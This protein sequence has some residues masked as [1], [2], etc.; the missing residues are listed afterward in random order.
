MKKVLLYLSALSTITTH[1]AFKPNGNI[2]H[3]DR[4]KLTQAFQHAFGT[5]RFSPKNIEPLAQGLSGARIYKVTQSDGE[6][7]IARIAGDFMETNLT[8]ELLAMQTASDQEYGPK[9]L[10]KN[11][12]AKTVILEYIDNDLS[13]NRLEP[14]FHKNAA[15]IMRKLHATKSSAQQK[16]ILE[17]LNEAEQRLQIL[18]SVSPL[19]LLTPSDLKLYTTAKKELEK[20][21]AHLA[22]DIRL[23]HQDLNPRNFL[24]TKERLWLIDWE[25]SSRNYFYVDL[26]VFANFH[27]YNEAAIEDFLTAYFQRKPTTSELAKFHLLRPFALMLHGLWLASIAN[28][29]VVPENMPRMPYFT[30]FRAMAYHRQIDMNLKSVQLGFATSRVDGAITL[31]KDKEYQQALLEIKKNKKS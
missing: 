21:S 31:L 14:A 6:A 8:N 18:G 15:K 9:L 27:I 13:I 4:A 26:A 5:K 30:E 17:W 3:E 2:P 23:V 24:A 20:L 1:Y 28:L 7:Y 22:G 29:K 12:K 16:L 11:L 19:N 10:Y 25:T